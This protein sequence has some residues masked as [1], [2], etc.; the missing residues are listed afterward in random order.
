MITSTTVERVYNIKINFQ[1]YNIPYFYIKNADE[2]SLNIDHDLGNTIT[3][4]CQGFPNNQLLN[5]KRIYVKSID[6]DADYYY[7]LD[8]L[9]HGHCV[10][11]MEHGELITSNLTISD[12]S[13]SNYQICISFHSCNFAFSDDILPTSTFLSNTKRSLLSLYYQQAVYERGGV[14]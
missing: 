8:E 1:D 12:L 4:D 2:I 10:L 5:G 6:F 3:I 13:T 14:A 7:G 9:K 11:N